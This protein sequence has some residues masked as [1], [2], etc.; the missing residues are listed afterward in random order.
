MAAVGERM[1]SVKYFD[2]IRHCFHNFPNN[3]FNSFVSASVFFFLFL[4]VV[5]W[6]LRLFLWVFVLVGFSFFFSSALVRR[7]GVIAIKVTLY[8]DTLA[9]CSQYDT[10]GTLPS[11]HCLSCGLNRLKMQFSPV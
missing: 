9:K 7:S 6:L 5:F 3:F 4:G 11:S 10:A 8:S 2:F 1:V